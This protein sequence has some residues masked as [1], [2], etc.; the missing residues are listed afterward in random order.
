MVPTTVNELATLL[1]ELGYATDG[2]A[3]ISIITLVIDGVNHPVTSVLP[4]STTAITMQS[5]VDIINN[6]ANV[7]PLVVA[8]LEMDTVNN[9]PVLR[10]RGKT[11][12]VKTVN[13]LD[14]ASFVANWGP[15]NLAQSI[16]GTFLDVTT[17]SVPS[18]SV[19]MLEPKPASPTFD[20]VYIPYHT[21]VVSDTP[22]LDINFWASL[23]YDPLD[24]ATS[25]PSSVVAAKH[26]TTGV[27]ILYT[28]YINYS[29][30][31]VE[32]RYA[33]S[34]NSGQ[35]VSDLT[36]SAIGFQPLP[37]GWIDTHWTTPQIL[38]ATLAYDVVSRRLFLKSLISGSIYTE[39]AH[40]AVNTT[41]L[42]ICELDTM[43]SPTL[44][45]VTTTAHDPIQNVT[46]RGFGVYQRSD[47]GFVIDSEHNLIVA[48][49]V[50]IPRTDSYYGTQQFAPGVE[51]TKINPSGGL[52]WQEIIE[53]GRYNATNGAGNP[54]I[55]G[56]GDYAQGTNRYYVMPANVAVSA[57]NDIF[58]SHGTC[59]HK[60]SATGTPIWTKEFD[61]LSLGIQFTARLVTD[62]QVHDT[63]GDV[64][65]ACCGFPAGGA[66]G[67]I[68][69]FADTNTGTQ[70]E[71]SGVTWLSE[72]PVIS[73]AQWS[74]NMIYDLFNPVSMKLDSTSGK[75]LVAT[76]LL[77]H[78]FDSYASVAA[79]QM[80][81]IEI[82]T[83]DMSIVWSND[84]SITSVGT[85]IALG[86]MSP[87]ATGVRA[88]G[89]FVGYTT[90]DFVRSAQGTA[91]SVCYGA[92]LFIGE[93]ALGTIAPT[94]VVVS[95]NLI[96][97]TV[98]NNT[99]DSAPEAHYKF[100]SHTSYDISSHNSRAAYMAGT[101]VSVY[102]GTPIIVDSGTYTTRHRSSWSDVVP[103]T[104]Y[105][106]YHN[107]TW[108]LPP[109]ASYN[110]TSMLVQN[111]AE[112]GELILGGR[113]AAPTSSIGT[114]LDRKGALRASS[115]GLHYCTA[116]YD[117]V[118]VIWETLPF[119]TVGR[120]KLDP[121]GYNN[122]TSA[123]SGCPTDQ[124]GDIYVMDGIIFQ[125]TGTYN[126]T[127]DIWTPVLP[128]Y[129]A[130]ITMSSSLT[131]VYD[132]SRPDLWPM[133]YYMNGYTVNVSANATSGVPADLAGGCV[134]RPGASAAI[135]TFNVPRSIHID[136]SNY[137]VLWR[138]AT[139]PTDSPVVLQLEHNGVNVG[140]VGFA[141]G[142]GGVYLSGD[143]DVT[144]NLGDTLVVRAPATQDSTFADISF[145][146]RGVTV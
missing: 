55:I 12:A 101:P 126:G 88:N 111:I 5:V 35:L 9:V 16:S 73:A 113:I 59:F 69:K 13:F 21:E 23:K 72:Q 141:Q 25:V 75:M 22:V 99:V 15:G 139:G 123:L 30:L 92:P 32:A 127:S 39:S 132:T 84:V 41:V 79:G 20:E 109:A 46:Q 53:S 145:S 19:R 129:G 121:I 34:A 143:W 7:G 29:E 91:T 137:D 24:N 31:V 42:S 38:S 37:T 63:T 134:G 146:I 36:N 65:V 68:F 76:G 77:H 117:G 112:V 119:G 94:G 61:Q 17:T 26:P 67:A 81:L 136:S 47:G 4:A 14:D 45:W 103:N 44:N 116:D 95:Q 11:T 48:C 93:G 27:D 125:C 62:I 140:A 50:L 8:S 56:N 87:M 107:F 135:M 98:V 40:S 130:G 18:T 105:T 96:T 97:T 33:N 58:V 2:V 51:I 110:K 43:L 60:L 74:A 6:D 138:C 120:I 142:T 10:L 108:I 86:L 52:I 90:F 144:L 28:V 131:T 102:N 66:V 118:G 115:T 104:M 85:A 70:Q 114:A 124:I 57:T 1:I 49:N 3:A 64:Y 54:H 122:N 78:G 128:T 100:E 83:N 82:N 133:N 89:Q 80:T 106:Q 71:C